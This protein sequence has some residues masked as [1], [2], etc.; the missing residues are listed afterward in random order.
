M[1]LM[2]ASICLSNLA[3]GVLVVLLFEL[4]LGALV[5][6]AVIDSRRPLPK[7]LLTQAVIMELRCSVCRGYTK[8]AVPWAQAGQTVWPQW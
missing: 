3:L 8:A 6:P 1:H 4:P 7:I 2:Q 5:G